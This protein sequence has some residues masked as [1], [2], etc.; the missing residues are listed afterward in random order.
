MASNHSYTITIS[1]NKSE[2][3]AI[4]FLLDSDPR[5]INPDKEARKLIME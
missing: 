2:K 3:E 1:N 4:Q 5:F